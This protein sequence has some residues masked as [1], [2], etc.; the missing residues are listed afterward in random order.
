M[1]F[2]IV[3]CRCGASIPEHKIDYCNRCTEEGEEY[4]EA[5]AE[6]IV[7]KAEYEVSQ[8]MEW[9]DRTDAINA[10]IEHIEDKK[11]DI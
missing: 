4:G 7:C 10:L 3:V 8:W 11:E 2:S 9:E 6:C 1:R 5:S